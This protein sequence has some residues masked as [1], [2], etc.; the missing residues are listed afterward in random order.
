MWE[1]VLRR[2]AADPATTQLQAMTTLGLRSEST[3][4]NACRHYE[5]GRWEAPALNSDTS[6]QGIRWAELGWSSFVDEAD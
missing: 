2:L 1:A 4:Q 3:L 5:I 6:G